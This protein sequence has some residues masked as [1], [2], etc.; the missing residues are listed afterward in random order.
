MNAQKRPNKNICN[1]Y[2]SDYCI[3]NGY[4][5]ESITLSRNADNLDCAAAGLSVPTRVTCTIMDMTLFYFISVLVAISIGL[6]A[7]TRTF[8]GIVSAIVVFIITTILITPLKDFINFV[9]DANNLNCASGAITTGTNMLCIVFDVWLFYFFAAA[10]AAAVTFIF[11][12][13][14]K[15][16]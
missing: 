12:K 4:S 13:K 6:I 15:P 2:G 9:R 3:Y 7:G 16:R 5:A 1:D 10:I 14:V 8:M 11:I